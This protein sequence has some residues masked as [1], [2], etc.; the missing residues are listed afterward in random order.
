MDSPDN[1]S[2]YYSVSESLV[3]GIPYVVITSIYLPLYFAIIVTLSN[4]TEY[5]GLILY[6]ILEHI[7]IANLLSLLS[8]LT[9]GVF[10]LTR[11]KFHGVLDITAGS[12][13]AWFRIGFILLN[14]LLS[15]NQLSVAFHFSIPYERDL[16]KYL[17]FLI[18]YALIVLVLMTVYLNFD[19][20]YAFESHYYHDP[21]EKFEF[22]INACRHVT[23]AIYIVTV[24]RVI[25]LKFVRK[26]ALDHRELSALYQTLALHLPTHIVSIVYQ[27]FASQ[28]KASNYSKL[29]YILLY[30]SLPAVTITLVLLLNRNLYK[31]VCHQVSKIKGR[32]IAVV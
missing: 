3:L 21:T 6:R 4:K 17:I 24:F 20:Y 31:D 30:R 27:V 22:I 2:T 8:M 25:Y 29:T 7:S 19:F 32:L 14:I 16:H 12:F 1:I 5:D 23:T 26:Q 28:I 10:E 13:A 11:V 18:W 15:L 9:C